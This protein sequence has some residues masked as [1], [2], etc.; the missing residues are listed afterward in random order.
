VYFGTEDS[1]SYQSF[2]AV[3]PANNGSNGNSGGSGGGGGGAVPA[4]SPPAVTGVCGKRADFNCD[5]RVDA[6]DFSILL[7]FWDS[8][9]PFKNQYVDLNKD[10]KVNATDFSILLYNWGK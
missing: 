7:Y 6:I 3:A 9:P 10:G 4:A 8:K 2:T 1:V 5:G